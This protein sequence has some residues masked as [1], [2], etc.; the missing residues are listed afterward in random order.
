MRNLVSE[1]AAAAYLGC[2]IYKL[3]RDRRIG[4][5][6]EFIKVGRS[7]RYDVRCLEIYLNSRTFTSTSQYGGK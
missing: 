7:V 4:A 5:G 2:S 1:Q 6:P 3:Q